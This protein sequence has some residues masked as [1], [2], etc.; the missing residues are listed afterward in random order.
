MMNTLEMIQERQAIEANR[1]ADKAARRVAK[2]DN[3]R[4]INTAATRQ[5]AAALFAQT[6]KALFRELDFANFPTG[7]MRIKFEED[8]TPFKFVD[9]LC[10]FDPHTPGLEG[11]LDGEHTVI[12]D[13]DGTVIELQHHPWAEAMTQQIV[14]IARLGY[15]LTSG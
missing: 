10:D 12:I 6:P 14:V 1:K 2:R 9:V 7:K 8:S 13:Y 11:D 5:A 4:R 15:D 3:Q